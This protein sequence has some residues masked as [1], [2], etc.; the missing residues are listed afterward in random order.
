MPHTRHSLLLPEHCVLC[1]TAAYKTQS[2]FTI[3]FF[4]VVRASIFAR[5]WMVRCCRWLRPIQFPSFTP[6]R[7]TRGEHAS[8]HTI[9]PHPIKV[10]EIHMAIDKQTLIPCDWSHSQDILYSVRNNSYARVSERTRKWTDEEEID[11]TRFSERTTHSR[12]ARLRRQWFV[13]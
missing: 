6:Q 8:K 4:V 9:A 12:R 13:R 10:R 7:T 3:I 5:N 11:L 2:H 1:S